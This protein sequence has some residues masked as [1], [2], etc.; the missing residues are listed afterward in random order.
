MRADGV[1]VARGGPAVVRASRAGVRGGFGRAVART[2]VEL[3]A[4]GGT[5]R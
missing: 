1:S 3:A 2:A 4:R 5:L